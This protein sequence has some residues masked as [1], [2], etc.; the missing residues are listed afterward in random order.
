[1]KKVILVMMFGFIFLGV[2]FAAATEEQDY[3][4]TIEIFKDSPVVKRF[5]ENAYGYAVFPIIG[6]GG[7]VVGGSYGQGQVYRDGKVT[8]KTSVVEGS[9]GFQFGG[10]AFS[11]IIFF[12]DKRAYDKFTSGSFEFGATVQAVAITAGA[13]VQAGTTGAS[14][15]ASAGPR[16]GAQAEASYFNGMAVFVHSQ[17]G[18]MLDFS[19]AGQK[20]FFEPI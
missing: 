12:Q 8:G 1:M 10:K 13:Q 6:K 4:A 18:L 2:T 14:A 20:F 16:T 9:I 19:I 3:S 11:E 15:G 17:G 7:W 5:F